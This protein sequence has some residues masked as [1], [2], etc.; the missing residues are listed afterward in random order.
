MR[1]SYAEVEAALLAR[2]PES[3]LE[4]SLDRIRA[5]CHLMGD[6]QAAYPVVHVTGTNGKTSV[7]R[8]VDS[9]LRTLA[10]MVASVAGFG[11]L[12]V[13]KY[14]FLD[15]LMFGPEHHTPY[16]EDEEQE[17]AVAEASTA[18]APEI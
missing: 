5:L 9:L 16:D 14:L 7:A 15:K 2:W 4:P 17:L 11:I 3:R 13:L 1:P 18:G 8:M 6:P 12:W 10:V